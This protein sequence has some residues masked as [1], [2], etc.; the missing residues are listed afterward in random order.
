M[1]KLSRSDLILT[2]LG[3]LGLTVV[4][5]LYQSAF[6][7]ALVEMEVTREEAVANATEFVE[8]LGTELD[9]FRHAAIFSGDSEAL[10]FLQRNVGNE[11]AGR[12]AREEVPVWRWDIRWFRPLDAEE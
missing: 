11:E 3:V 6:P 4:V 10:T 9:D 2:V 5:A 8:G 7:L 1:L 12:C